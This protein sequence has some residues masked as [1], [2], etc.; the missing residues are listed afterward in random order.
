MCVFV[1]N[2][3]DCKTEYWMC[4]RTQHACDQVSKQAGRSQ[5]QEAHKVFRVCVSMEYMC[6]CRF[7]CVCVCVFAI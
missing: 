5:G 7:V 4:V 1:V 6:G 3:G 2:R